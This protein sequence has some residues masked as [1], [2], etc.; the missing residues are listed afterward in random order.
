M[1]YTETLVKEG[2]TPERSKAIAEAL[3]VL[4]AA[5]SKLDGAGRARF[6][7]TTLE[8]RLSEYSVQE[9]VTD[10]TKWINRNDTKR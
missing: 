5:V 7:E 6:F 9:D 4:H 10:V 3:D 1:P 8:T 2:F